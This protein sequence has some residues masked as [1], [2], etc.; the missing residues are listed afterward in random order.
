MKTKVIIIILMIFSFLSLY[1]NIVIKNESNSNIKI[2]SYHC[3]D[4]SEQTKRY[5]LLEFLYFRPGQIS[6]F[7]SQI[8]SI[9]MLKISPTDVI[10]YFV[11]KNIRDNCFYTIYEDNDAFKM[12]LEGALDM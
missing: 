6:V 12:V 2:R 11:V 9:D 7:S 8:D 5:H 1:T 4:S 10:G 3:I